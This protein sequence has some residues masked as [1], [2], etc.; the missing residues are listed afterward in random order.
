MKN[1]TFNILKL[2]AKLRNK[3]AI[4]ANDMKGEI[5]QQIQSTIENASTAPNSGIMP[6]MNMLKE[7][8]ASLA[9][10]VKRDG[11][12]ISVS[13]PSVQPGNVAGRYADL[14]NQIKNYLQKNIELFPSKRNEDSVDYDDLVIRLFYN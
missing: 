10:N 6:F 5:Q 14:P 11:N 3:Y 13:A 7:D 4:D 2:A 1:S 9:I 12:T 8:G